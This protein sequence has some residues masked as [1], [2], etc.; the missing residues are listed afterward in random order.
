[1]M[2]LYLFRHGISVEPDHWPGDDP[3]RP[4]TEMGRLQTRDVIQL[5]HSQRKIHPNEIWSSPW[6]R[7][8]QTAQ[9]ASEELNLAL[10]LTPALGS[11]QNLLKTLPLQHGDPTHWPSSLMLVG[12]QPDLGILVSQLTTSLQGGN[13]L[14]RAGMAFLRGNFRAGGM[15]L[16]WLVSAEE[17]LSN[18]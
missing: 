8:G 4:L 18:R 2:D 9:I 17:A 13:A 12:H 1:M 3:S 6:L 10:K 11:G 15:R 16:E 14:G 5:L 7:A